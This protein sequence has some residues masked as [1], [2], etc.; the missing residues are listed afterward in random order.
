MDE[1]IVVI[2]NRTYHLDQIVDRNERERLRNLA[3]LEKHRGHEL[4]H[5]EMFMILIFV[6]FGVQIFLIYWQKH[7]RKSFQLWTLISAA[8]IPFLY[9]IY[10]VYTRFLSIWVFAIIIF[11]Y[12]L[13]RIN[14]HP[15]E[16]S[17]PRLVY[18]FFIII[19]KVTYTVAAS[20]YI[21]LL[22]TFLNINIAF[23][24]SNE[25]SFMLGGYLLFYGTYFGLL[26][27]DLASIITERMAVKIG[28]YRGGDEDKLPISALQDNICAVCNH[29]LEEE[30]H[31]RQ[32]NND[33]LPNGEIPNIVDLGKTLKSPY[34]TINDR[35]YMELMSHFQDP[36][37]LSIALRDEIEESD[38][39]DSSTDDFYTYNRRRQRLTAI[40][41]LMMKVKKNKPVEY[42]YK[43]SCGH[44]FHEF[45]IRGWCMIGKKETCPYCSERVDLQRLFPTHWA[46]AEQMYGN[47]LDFLRYLLAWQPLIIIAIHYIYRILHLE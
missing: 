40:D 24:I 20:G 14:E 37:G 5:M 27:R 41:I 46:K 25:T 12:I 6:L 44:T 43:L 22:F 39:D 4:M 47:L 32:T 38:S 34:A 7:Y 28:H 35:E 30:S 18:Q 3:M 2:A 42:N 26:G 1:E 10:Y 19:Y 33:A 13:K 45:C 15:M 36:D 11:L 29:P 31:N 17:T 8:V 16:P 23:N 21:A 9:S